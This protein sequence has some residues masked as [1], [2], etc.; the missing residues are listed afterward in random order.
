[1]WDGFTGALDAGL[2]FP[3]EK[4]KL[5]LEFVSCERLLFVY[6]KTIIGLVVLENVYQVDSYPPQSS[7]N[8]LI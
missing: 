8:K 3:L 2:T 7:M 1:M 4:W 6:Y 5:I